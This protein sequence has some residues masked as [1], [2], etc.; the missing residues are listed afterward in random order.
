MSNRIN[1]VVK[2]LEDLEK[3]LAAKDGEIDRLKG[4]V[5]TL[6]HALLEVGK[7]SMAMK[8]LIGVIQDIPLYEDVPHYPEPQDKGNPT[9]K[10]M[11][12]GGYCYNDKD[13]CSE[14]CARRFIKEQEEKP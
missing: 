8:D 12:C 6:R 7:T 3:E 2:I 5:N 4:E 14:G 13:I 10:C 1:D 9:G 11:E